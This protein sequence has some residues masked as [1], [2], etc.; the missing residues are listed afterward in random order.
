MTLSDFQYIYIYSENIYR[1]FIIL[2]EE[3]DAKQ[4]YLVF[5]VLCR[6]TDHLQPG[7][8]IAGGMML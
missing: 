2:W 3:D 5:K 4:L 1:I 6:W 8:L 7:T